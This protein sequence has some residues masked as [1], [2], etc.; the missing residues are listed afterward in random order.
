[1]TKANQ[2]GHERMAKNTITSWRRLSGR[3]ALLLTVS[4]CPSDPKAGDVGAG[5]GGSPEGDRGR[6]NWNTCAQSCRRGWTAAEGDSG[7][8]PAP[9]R[10]KPPASLPFL[11]LLS[12][13]FLLPHFLAFSLL[14]FTSSRRRKWGVG[15]RRRLY[16]WAANLLY[17]AKEI[18]GERIKLREGE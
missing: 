6:G 14:S 4:V 13:A 11:F 18:R 3:Q 5:S 7:N 15:G 16:S 1:M 17:P 2:K 8:T 9:A 12:L 10:L